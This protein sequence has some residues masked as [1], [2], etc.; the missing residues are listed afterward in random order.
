M[1]VD[2][3]IINIDIRGSVTS[4]IRPDG[5]LV[6]GYIYDE[7]GNQKKTGDTDFINDA[8]YTGAIFD[9]ETN[10]VYM[11]AR[12]YDSSSGRFIA[13]D[14][15][16]GA[17]S[18]PQTQH[19]YSYPSN[20]PI[21]YID[22]TGYYTMSAN[23]DQKAIIDKNGNVTSVI[24][25]GAKKPRTPKNRRNAEGTGINS[26]DGLQFPNCADADYFGNPSNL[27]YFPRGILEEKEAP[28]W[29]KYLSIDLALML[30]VPYWGVAKVI[31]GTYQ[32]FETLYETR[33]LAGTIGKTAGEYVGNKMLE[34][35]CKLLTGSDVI[36]EGCG[37]AG[38]I[39]R[40]I[41]QTGEISGSNNYTTP[42]IPYSVEWYILLEGR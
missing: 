28:K 30:A 5:T 7:F 8:T 11:N 25:E 39:V 26:I 6:S 29:I 12:Y 22:T 35:A 2:Y 23:E 37:I 15:Y 3:F 41:S 42:I 20:N 40:E 21:N 10:L 38:D 32:F 33:D 34:K 31:I 14:T 13:Q 16:K 36:A 1:T 4:I 17:I 18:N 9:Q 27:C 24:R 19:L